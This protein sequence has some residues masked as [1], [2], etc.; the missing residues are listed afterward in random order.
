MLQL[1]A[2]IK[3]PSV[4]REGDGPARRELDSLSTAMSCPANS[5]CVSL[6]PSV[7]PAHSQRH[8]DDFGDKSVWRS[9]QLERQQSAVLCVKMWSLQSLWG[10]CLQAFWNI[11]RNSAIY[12]KTCMI[13]VNT[14]QI[15]T[16]FKHTLKKNVV[17]NRSC[18]LYEISTYR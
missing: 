18:F 5:R 9:F 17:W 15:K 10:R 7:W 13:Q 4:L 3:P 2:A 11:V 14:M 8:Y 12:G 6:K 16:K 1:N